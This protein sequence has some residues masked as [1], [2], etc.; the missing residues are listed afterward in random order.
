LI[1][2][3]GEVELGVEVL[4][5]EDSDAPV[6]AQSGTSLVSHI[7]CDVV[8]VLVIEGSRPVNNCLD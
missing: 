2:H 4:S 5:A 6:A 1:S 7:F 3:A 8:D